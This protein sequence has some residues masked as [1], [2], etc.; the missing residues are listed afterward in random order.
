LFYIF[1]VVDKERFI[2]DNDAKGK[3][4]YL[5]VAGMAAKY[6]SPPPKIPQ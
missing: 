5:L 4:I 2:L 6:W 3:N 1:F